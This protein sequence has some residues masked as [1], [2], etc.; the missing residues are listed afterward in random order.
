MDNE[1]RQIS[2][3]YSIRKQNLIYVQHEEEKDPRTI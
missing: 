1:Q 2:R 3:E